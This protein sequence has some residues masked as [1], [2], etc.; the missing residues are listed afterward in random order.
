MAQMWP[1]RGS[2]QFELLV[3]GNSPLIALH[4]TITFCK[5]I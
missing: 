3:D 1:F 2:D 4:V 5:D